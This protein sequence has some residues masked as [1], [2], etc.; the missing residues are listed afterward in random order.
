MRLYDFHCKACGKTFEDLVNDPSDARCPACRSADV[1]KEQFSAFSVG[2]SSS[3]KATPSGGGGC[4][5][6]MCGMGGCGMS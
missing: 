1:E 4:G 6:G 3:G 2:G 5:S